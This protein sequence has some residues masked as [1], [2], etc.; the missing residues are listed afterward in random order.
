MRYIVP[1]S[2][3]ALIFTIPPPAA[4]AQTLNDQVVL[5]NDQT[6]LNRVKQAAFTQAL[7]VSSDALTTG[8]N[9]KRHA[10]VTTIMNDANGWKFQLASAIVT[11][12]GVINPAT[13]N[14]TV[15]LT[16]MVCYGLPT[17]C[18]ETGNVKVQQALITDTVINNT[19]SA[20]FNAFFGGQ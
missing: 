3:F 2:L 18:V 8:V 9:I 7:A 16:P 6:F 5:A 20:V 14:G 17:G 10:Q 13:A 12:A 4:A 11:Q 19:I 15:A 1:L